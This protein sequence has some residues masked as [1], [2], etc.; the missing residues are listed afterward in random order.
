M[1]PFKRE[2][3]E[4]ISGNYL[5]HFFFVLGKVSI[6]NSFISIS[7]SVFYL[8]T[9]TVRITIN[10]TNKNTKK[11]NYFP[12]GEKKRFLTLAKCFLRICSSLIVVI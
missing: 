4:K 5:K 6:C 8:M 12:I 1:T 3:G 7:F 10:K 9:I 2:E 11:Y